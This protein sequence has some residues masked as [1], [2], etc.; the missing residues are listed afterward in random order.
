MAGYGGAIKLKGESEYRKAL[1]GITQGLKEV[2]AQMRLT[3]ATYDKNDNSTKSLAAQSAN[4]TDKLGLQEAKLAKLKQQYV[5]MNSQ[6]SESANKHKELIKK[7]DEE[8]TKLELIGNTLGKTSPE[9]LAQKEVVKGLAKEVKQSTANQDAN[10]TSMSNMRIKIKN[11]ETD[12]IKTKN[13][14]S[15]LDG[16]MKKNTE[17]SKAVN[18]AYGTLKSTISQQENELKSL[19]T[20][21]SNVVLEQGE[22]SASAKQLASQIQNLGGKLSENKTKL[23]NTEKAADDLADSLTNS[24]KKAEKASDGF[25]VLK[26]T[27]ANLVSNGVQKLASA[28]TGQLDSAISRV[29]TI[30]SYSKT[31]KNLGYTSEDVTNS[32]N[33]LKEGILGLPTTLPGIISMQ[34][35]YSAL[36]GDISQATDLT[37]ALNNATLAG[38][39]GQ[40]VANSAMQQWYQIIANGKPDA[41]AWQIISSA[42]PAQMNQIAESTMGAGK[43]SQD[44]FESWKSGKVTTNQVISSLIK[45]NSEGGGGLSSFA[46]QAKDST[47]GIQTSMSN[48]KTAIATGTANVIEEVGSEK[49]ATAMNGFKNIVAKT[50]EAVVESMNFIEENKDSIV[51]ALTAMGVGIATYTAYTTAVQIM[52]QGWKSLALVQKLVEMSTWAMNTAMAVNPI[53]LVVAAVAA[54]VAGFVVLWNKS[55][56]FRNFWIGLWDN[57]KTAAEPIVTALSE[58]FSKAWE[59]IQEVWEPV[60][61]FFSNLFTGIKDSVEPIMESISN[62]FSKAW[63]LIKVVWDLV[64]PY[65]QTLWDNIVIIFSV[66]KDVLSA[67]FNLAWENIK[68]VWEFVAPYFQTVWD[69]IK[70]VFSVVKDVL[71]AAFETA[72][73]AIKAVWDTVV[74]FFQAIWDS[75]AAVFDVV[76]KVLTG[77]FQGAW[78]GIKGI[79]DTWANFFSKT[80]ENIKKVFSGVK[81]FFSKSFQSAADGIK[82]IFDNVVDFFSGIWDRIKKLFTKLGDNIG[83]AIGGSVSSAINSVISMIQNTINRAIGIINGAIN[84]INKIPGVSV[85]KV[86]EVELPRLA[87]GGVVNRSTIAEIGENGAEAIV[88]LENN[89]KW[90]KKV[91]AEIQYANN[92]NNPM[93]NMNSTYSYDNMVKAFKEALRGVAVEMDG[94]EMGKFVDKTVTNLIYT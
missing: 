87:R 55:E 40:E 8:K 42:M 24:G 70:V 83:S 46:E 52:T 7:Y 69:N 90:I 77:D 51:A 63:E 5:S 75:I 67:G 30:N 10:A 1:Q 81:D 80:W 16:E 9:Y 25:T 85:G 20:Q 56:G 23:N 12:I 76:K 47:G 41:T 36:T 72:W 11:A 13:S 48:I 31:M 33:K 2:S 34:Q 54:L 92:N 15:A 28:I 37:L 58:W 35:Q 22:S 59:K 86:S 44:L 89:T 17:S 68:A 57:I 65:F 74:A 88:P 43:K 21:Y 32:M 19:K 38:G 45:L 62:A 27:L 78:D 84:L 3:A 53:G 50:F 18:S 26:G 71:G 61:E 14:I 39:Q 93:Q 91:A 94:D 4:L 79:V 82:K 49:I 29:D 66:V 6:Y 64:S 60:S 73:T